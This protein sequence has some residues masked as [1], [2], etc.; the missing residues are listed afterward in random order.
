MPAAFTESLAPF[1]N[2]PV[3]LPHIDLQPSANLTNAFFISF[4]SWS[5]PL[6]IFIFISNAFLSIGLTV[7]ANLET[8]VFAL[9]SAGF[10][11]L[12]ILLGLILLNA[13]PNADFASLANLETEPFVLLNAPDN[14]S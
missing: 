12:Y 9:L 1:L 13:S 11:L 8:A 7:P 5:I 2:M 6:Y 10:M 14:A 4:K 3:I